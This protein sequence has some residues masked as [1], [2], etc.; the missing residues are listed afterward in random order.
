M[1]RVKIAHNEK[2]NVK[3]LYHMLAIITCSWL[4]TKQRNGLQKW[5][6]EYSSCGV[7]DIKAVGHGGASTVVRTFFSPSHGFR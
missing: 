3:L 1:N 2:K 6:N 7:I 5:G 4:R